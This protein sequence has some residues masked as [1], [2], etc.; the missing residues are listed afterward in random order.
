MLDW[1]PGLKPNV[2]R[3][4]WHFNILDKPNDTAD[5][6][7]ERPDKRQLV[8]PAYTSTEHLEPTIPLPL[9]P[10]EQEISVVKTPCPEITIGP[11]LTTLVEKLKA[12]DFGELEARDFLKALQ[13]Q[14]AFR[15][16]PLQPTIPMCF[17]RM[18]VEGKSYSTG[19]PVFE[20]Q[21]QAAVSGDYMTDMQHN[22]AKFTESTCHRSHHSKEPLAFS[23]CT[24]G[25][26]MQLWVHYTTSVDNVRMYQMN[27]LKICHASRL[28]SLQE[29]VQEFFE[30]VDGVISWAASDLLDEV[31]EQLVLV[32][33]GTQQGT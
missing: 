10:L 28:P 17:P 16:S 20:A 26:M 33:K 27:I 25:P 31:A 22:L 21:N 5:D 29:G 12:R 4:T 18:V 3:K 19:R 1:D 24:E 32:S 13:N 8:E 7:L 6:S 30:A 9:P 23:I 14:Q 11:S 2:Q 15:L